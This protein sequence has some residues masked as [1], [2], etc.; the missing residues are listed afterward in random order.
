[1][2]TPR[3]RAFATMLAVFAEDGSG[4]DLSAAEGERRQP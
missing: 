3:G 1:M 4:V 2:T